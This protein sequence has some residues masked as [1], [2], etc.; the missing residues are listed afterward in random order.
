MLTKKKQR[1]YLYEKEQQWLNELTIFGE[2]QDENAL[3]RLRLGIKKIRALVRLTEGV[4]GKR[5][6]GDLRPLKKMFRQAGMIRDTRSQLRLLEQ[7]QLLSPDHRELR[8]LQLK[9]AAD[10]FCRCVTDYR[11]EGRKAARLLLADVEAIHGRAIR[12]WFAGEIIQAGV[13]LTKSGDELHLARKKIKTLLYVQKMLPEKQVHQ[14]RLDTDYLDQIQDA[15]GSWHDCVVA[16]AGR[17]DQGDA[18]ESQMIQ[19]CRAKEQII[20]VLAD[21]FHRKVHR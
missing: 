5:L 6:S 21:D 20:R 1:Q 12:R 9:E 7:H 3:H 2:T 19:E 8:V 15:I 11:K 14:L 10:K 18:G 16:A 17:P 13:L 4:R